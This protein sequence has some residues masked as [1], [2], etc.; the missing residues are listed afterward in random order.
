MCVYIYICMYTCAVYLGV[1]RD[2]YVDIAPSKG[3]STIL[4]IYIYACGIGRLDI[5]FLYVKG[6]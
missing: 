5:G 6:W 4:Y 2:T 3:F 1:Y